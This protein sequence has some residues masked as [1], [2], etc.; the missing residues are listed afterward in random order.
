MRNFGTLAEKNH[1]CKEFIVY[2]FA[3]AEQK[4]FLHH[5]SCGVLCYFA[6]FV[7]TIVICYFAIFV[8]TE[9]ITNDCKCREKCNPEERP[10][11]RST[12][13]KLK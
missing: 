1:D 4:L 11:K 7:Q 9:V 2:I 13:D 3:E 10:M 12:S 5:S 6:V 8:Q